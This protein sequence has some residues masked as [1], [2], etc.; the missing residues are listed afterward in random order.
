MT[1][2]GWLQIFVFF[3][4][5]FLVTKPLGVF[6]ARVY[7]RKKTF[8]DPVLRPIERLIYKLTGVDEQHEMRWTEYAFAMLCFSLVPMIVLYAIE[9][10]Q[11]WLPWN[12][13]KLGAVAT[14][15]AFNTAASFTTNTNWQAYMP[16]AT[17]SYFT[18]MAGPGVSQLHVRRGGHRAG[19]RGD[20]RNRAAGAGHDWE[21]LGGY[22]ADVAVG[23]AAGVPG[24]FAWCL[25]RRA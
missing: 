1:A 20:S 11:Q 5:V 14:D 2:N 8:L 17:M 25:C 24:D 18:Q 15:L 7:D 6:M 13:Q 22:D 4:A 10:V 12:P 3:A 16:E 19:D 9:R 21:F 23:S